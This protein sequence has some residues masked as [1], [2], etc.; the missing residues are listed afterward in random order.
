[1]A[2]LRTTKSIRRPAINLTLSPEAIRRG[3]KLQKE[4]NRPSLS[5][6]VEH[7]LVQADKETAS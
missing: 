7:L 3:R 6:V 5:N 4:M 1:M 2:K